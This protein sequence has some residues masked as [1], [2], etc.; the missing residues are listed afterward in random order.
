MFT[1]TATIGRGAGDRCLSE[2][3][4]A[5][6][7]DHVNQVFTDIAL[8]HDDDFVEVHSGMGNWQGIEEESTKITLLTNIELDRTMIGVIRR[9][10]EALAE[11]YDQDAIA[12][13][14]GQSEL[15]FG[16]RELMTN[17]TL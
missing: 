3:K 13:T 8:G 6:F 1:Y 10:L 12:F 4:W 17:Y 2:E 9:N 7:E 5:T 11:A 15:C 14:I 16:K